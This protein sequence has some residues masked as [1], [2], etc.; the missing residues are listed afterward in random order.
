MDS[1]MPARISRADNLG[2]R[3]T[4]RRA[5]TLVELL[6]VIGIIAVLM[7]ILL[8]AL[9]RARESANQVKC[10]SNLRSIGQGIA[11]YCAEY[12]GKY[13]AAYLYV[14]QKT[15]PG[16]A[17]GEDPSQGY[18]HLS[19]YLYGGKVGVNDE[20]RLYRSEVGWEMFQCPSIERGGLP[21]TN[22][23]P[24]NLDGGQTNDTPGV[25]DRQAPRMAY[26]FNEALCPRNK[27]YVGFQGAARP[28]QFV[29][30]G[31]VKDASNTVLAT[32]FNPSWR[33]VEDSGRTDP[34]TSVCKSHRPVHGFV[35]KTGELN[36]EKIASLGVLGGGGISI[37]KC[38][39]Q[40]LLPDPMP[41]ATLK[42]R[43]DWVGRNHGKKNKS[44]DGWDLRQTNFLYADGHVETK[45]IRDTVEPTFQW[46]WTFYSLNPNTDVQQ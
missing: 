19:S 29:S 16:G 42:S 6:V 7:G 2:S 15:T 12:R 38:R 23:I 4:S 24:E 36:M 18:L 34:G 41:G 40:D 26:T 17:G 22:T 46:G 37:L 33:I 31:S 43:L 32:E 10:S 13:P 1:A 5:F 8:P 21:P 35:G 9:G 28:Y 14:N 45:H 44:G 27:F 3:R 20:D 30:A 25:V 39:I 11:M